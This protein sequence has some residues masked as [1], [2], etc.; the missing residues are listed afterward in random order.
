MHRNHW[1][2]WLLWKV[3]AAVF[4]EVDSSAQSPEQFESSVILKSPV[5]KA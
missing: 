2:L 4:E 5:W 1:K 3:V